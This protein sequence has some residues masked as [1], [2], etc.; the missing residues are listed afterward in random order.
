MESTVLYIID[1]LQRFSALRCTNVMFVFSNG[2]LSIRVTFL[3]CILIIFVVLSSRNNMFSSTMSWLFCLILA[4]YGNGV[5]H[6]FGVNK[7][8]VIYIVSVIIC[9]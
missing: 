5:K 1:D 4:H 9:D 7:T 6:S 8:Q 2:S 3:S